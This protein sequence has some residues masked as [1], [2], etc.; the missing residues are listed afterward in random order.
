M[1]SALRTREPSK[2]CAQPSASV[3]LVQ[4]GKDRAV[5]AVKERPAATERGVRTCKLGIPRESG[6]S[7]FAGRDLLPCL[8]NTGMRLI[9]WLLI[10]A[11]AVLN[12][13][14]P[15]LHAHVA[16]G[17]NNGGGLHLPSGLPV[18]AGLA[19]H[20]AADAPADRDATPSIE[21]GELVRQGRHLRTVAGHV[22]ALWLALPAVHD[23]GAPRPRSASP[24]GPRAGITGRPPP[25]RGP[26]QSTV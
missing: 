18:A 7:R 17:P 12:G 2:S 15:L 10:V 21:L 25:A 3:E 19:V 1:P 9:Q 26:P 24:P 16:D 23:G 6:S 20:G 14:A 13:A 5:T 11:F 4:D 8:D 22:A